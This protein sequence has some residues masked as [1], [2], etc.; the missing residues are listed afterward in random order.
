MQELDAGGKWSDSAAFTIEIDAINITVTDSIAP[1]DDLSLPYGSVTTG[2]SS[3][4]KVIVTND[5]TADLTIT[6]I[7]QSNPLS[8]PFS[9][10]ADNCSNKTLPAGGSCTL[11]LRFSPTAAGTFSDSFD[12]PSNDP[13]ENPVTMSVSGT[14]TESNEPDITVTDFIAPKSDLGVP[15]GNVTVNSSSDSVVTV[16]ND[17][18]TFLDIGIIGFDNPLSAPFSIVNDNCTEQSLDAARSC[19]FTVRFSPTAAGTFSDSFEIPSNDPDE[20]PV[21]VSVSGTGTTDPVQDISVLPTEVSFNVSVGSSSPAQTVTIENIGTGD[22]SINT[23]TITGTD[24]SEFSIQND[25]CSGQT[26]TSSGNCTV[27]V[28]FSPAS[29]GEKSASLTIPSDDPDTSSAEVSLTGNP[30]I[31]TATAASSNG[32]ISSYTVADSI[33][34][35]PPA[36]TPL[37]SISFTVNDVVDSVDI[38]F[39]FPSL[40]MNSKVYKEVGGTWNTIYPSNQC[41]GISNVALDSSN[42]TLSFTIE[43]NS[44]CDGDPATGTIQDPVVLGEEISTT[45]VGGGGGGG[46]F[47]A[48]AAFLLLVGGFCRKYKFHFISA[49]EIR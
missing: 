11:Y 22:L 15:F 14:G 36:F 17:G 43:D 10:I 9:I 39:T 41:D 31:S 7:A 27:E 26:L 25:N 18:S 32:T 29:S 1:I 21:T 20:N 13:D 6:D 38:T 12:I 34:G 44:E 47:I 8:A 19:M 37:K 48:I 23:I 35:S 49:H 16:T 42:N 24:S 45:V 33:A 28:I 4:Q 40:P 3:D 30:S 2:S 46:F 5:G